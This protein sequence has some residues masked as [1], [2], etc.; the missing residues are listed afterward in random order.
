MRFSP[1]FLNVFFFA[2]RPA[3][4]FPP[5]VPGVAVGSTASFLAILFFAHRVARC[6]VRGA[7]RTTQHALRT[8][9]DSLLLRYRALARS[10]ARAGVGLGPLAAHRQVAP[11]AQAAPAA[12]F[13]Q[14]LDVHRDFLAQVAFDA[15]L[16]LDDAADLAHVV[17]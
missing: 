13:H 16:L 12:D 15:P 10:L 14:P 4:F 17:L 1:R 2:G 7:F 3:G 5:S 11:V 9:L 8:T 6:A